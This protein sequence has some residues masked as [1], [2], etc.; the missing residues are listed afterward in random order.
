MK[1]KIYTHFKRDI[2][3][4]KLTVNLDNGLYRDITIQ[5]PGSRNMQYHITTRPGFLMFTGDMGCFVFERSTDMFDFFRQNDLKTIN[6]GYWAEKLEGHDSR[7]GHKEVDH[8]K[9]RNALKSD[10]KD[11]LANMDRSD[12]EYRQNRADA[13]GAVDNFCR[14]TEEDFYIHEIQNWDA[15]CAGGFELVDF[16]EHSTESHTFHYL[17]CCYAIVY[18]IHLYDRYKQKEQTVPDDEKALDLVIRLYEMGQQY[19]KLSHEITL[20]MNQ[21]PIKGG[22]DQDGEYIPAD[23]HLT[24]WYSHKM[25]DPHIDI[26]TEYEGVCKAC[27]SAYHLINERKEL[28]LAR[29]RVKAQIT[30][31][32]KVA[33]EKQNVE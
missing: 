21:C 11:F 27:M 12:P 22:M 3:K 15:D 17:W 30:K 24:R 16:W 19:K 18:A 31:L 8:E 33:G 1:T 2:R 25:R 20:T 13:I 32:G 29:G 28:R 23:R 26:T 10:L 5:K 9:I 14:Y 4:H 6:P 7:N